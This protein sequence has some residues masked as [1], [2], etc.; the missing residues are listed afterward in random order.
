MLAII[1]IIRIVLG[2]VECINEISFATTG[3][4]EFISKLR[5]LLLTTSIVTLTSSVTWDSPEMKTVK[6]L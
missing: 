4:K 2:T 1:T 6:I 5:A 3:S